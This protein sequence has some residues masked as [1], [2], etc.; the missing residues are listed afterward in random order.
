M[1]PTGYAV[2]EGRYEPFEM[3]LNDDGLYVY[4][5]E[6]IGSTK[7]K[8]VRYDRYGQMI[9][10]WYANYNGV[11]YYDLT[12]GAMLYGT[13]VINGKTY[14]FDELTGIMKF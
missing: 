14:F 7:G 8:W 9:K 1:F 6:E 4:Q 5:N 12:T 13:H 11:Y 3:T 2:S 10:S